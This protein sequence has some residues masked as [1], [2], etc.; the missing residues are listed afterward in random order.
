MNFSR[1]QVGR[2]LSGA[3]LS[4]WILLRQALSAPNGFQVDRLLG[5]H[6]YAASTDQHRAYR[7]EVVVSLLGLPIFSRSGVGSGF[8]SYWRAKEG[9]ITITKARF[10]GGSFPQKTH[11]LNRLGLIEEVV[12]EKDGAPVEAAYFGF[13]T[14]S[15]EEGASEARKALDGGN[16]EIP[17]VATEGLI[18]A[19]QFRATK[20]RFQFSNRWTWAD[21]KS[22]FQQ[23]RERFA[24][25]KAEVNNVTFPGDTWPGTFLHCMIKALEQNPAQFQAGYVYNAKHFGLRMDKTADAKAGGNFAAKGLTARPQ[26]VMQFRGVIHDDSTGKLTN[27][28]LWTEEGGETLLPLRIELQ[29]RSFLALAFEFDLM[30]QSHKESQDL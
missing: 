8:C 17:Y 21:R 19:T 3:L 14:S 22:I 10:A 7:A 23:V 2:L 27:F 5:E 20:T 1:R 29:A 11:N 24:T 4:N 25:T 15:P 18:L 13:M 9:D 28:R 12:I 16:A 6:A 26:S 30:L